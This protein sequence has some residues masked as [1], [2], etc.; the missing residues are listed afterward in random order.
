MKRILASILV[1]PISAWL[2]TAAVAEEETIP[3]AADTPAAMS[4]TGAT[5]QSSDST[6]GSSSDGPVM[7]T[8]DTDS[9]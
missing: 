5:P 8:P 1:L 7:S 9:K 3:T 2:S 6:T 4:D